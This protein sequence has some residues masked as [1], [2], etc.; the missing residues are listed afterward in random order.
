MK[1]P[2]QSVEV[3]YLIHA[4]EDSEKISTAV[5]RLTGVL[6]EPV[7][8]HLEGHFGNEITKARIQLTGDVA[9][10]AF[11]R[12]VV[13]MSDGMRK[14]ISADIGSFL[15]EHSAMF[16]RLDKQLLVSGSLALGS[17]DSVRVKVKPRLFL[18]KGG[19]PRFYADLM[20]GG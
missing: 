18:A 9:T 4:T 16:L 19:A 13:M 11:E 10:R 14:S 1:G 8:E 3:T 7:L 6:S 20:G 2:I 17:G 5:S 15:D 12:I